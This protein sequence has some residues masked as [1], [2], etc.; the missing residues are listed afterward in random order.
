MS[1]YYISAEN[2][3]CPNCGNKN[4][5]RIPSRSSGYL[6]RFQ[7][8]SDDLLDPQI[9]CNCGWIGRKTELLTKE[10]EKCLNRIKLIDEMLNG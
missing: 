4:L 9:R 7:K 1:N 10:M 3:R 2:H 8:L 5:E 6:C